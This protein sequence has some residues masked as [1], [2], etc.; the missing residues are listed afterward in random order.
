MNKIDR[1]ICSKCAYEK[2]NLPYNIAP[3]VTLREVVKAEKLT[4]PK[5]AKLTWFSVP[6]IAMI[7]QKVPSRKITIE[8]AFALEK[9]F[10]ISAE[11]WINLQTS[12]D[13]H[14]LRNKET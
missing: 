7:C 9:V 3:W 12:Y 6:S 11:F 2:L 1:I 13:L 8:L 5:L 4:Y 10:W 14:K